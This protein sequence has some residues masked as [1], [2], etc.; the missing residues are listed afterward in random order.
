MENRLETAVVTLREARQQLSN[1]RK[2]RGF[3]GPGSGSGRGA[4]KGLGKKPG[5]CHA[6][7]APG[8]WAGDAD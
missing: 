6:C 8:H 3:K 2:D 1:M 5:K 4:G 7:G